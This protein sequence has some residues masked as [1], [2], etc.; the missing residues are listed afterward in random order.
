MTPKFSLIIGIAVMALVFAAPAVAVI[1]TLDGGDTGYAKGDGNAVVVSQLPS[2]FWNYDANGQK[3][4]DASPGL[5]P[6]DLATQF[7]GTTGVTVAAT[8]SGRGDW[9]QIGIG[10]ALALLA[11]LLGV[12]LVMRHGRTRQLAH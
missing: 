4:A 5:A 6:Q 2:D 8:D 1:P 11:A 3:I 10:L 12:M 9:P 7:A